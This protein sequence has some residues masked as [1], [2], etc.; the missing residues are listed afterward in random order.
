MSKKVLVIET[1][2]RMNSNTDLMGER[3]AAGAKDAGNEVEVESLK[4]DAVR[5]CRGCYACKRNGR[6]VISDNARNLVDK[7]GKVDVVA[8]ATPV[9]F[10]GMSGQMKTLLDR[11]MPLYWP[12]AGRR[13]TDVYLMV[14][15]EDTADTLPDGVI[16]DVQRWAS[17]FDGVELKNGV[18]AYGTL[19]PKSV[20]EEVLQQCYDMGRSIS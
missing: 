14:A 2:I 16:D 17:C 10:Y 7:M 8:F 5:Y 1:S 6:C 15:G 3:F 13:F 19:D 12:V 18:C 4:G 11:T 9:Y 20:S